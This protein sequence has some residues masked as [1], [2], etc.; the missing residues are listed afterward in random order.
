MIVPLFHFLFFFYLLEI[1]PLTFLLLGIFQ[2][3]PNVSQLQCLTIRATNIL[4]LPSLSHSPDLSGLSRLNLKV[5]DVDLNADS[6]ATL[7]HCFPSGLKELWLIVSP[8]NPNSDSLSLLVP[9]FQ[10]NPLLH[11]P[12]L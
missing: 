7:F 4:Q 9:L 10:E 11:L 6:I 8:V 12:F 5:D 2:V 1:E 3:L